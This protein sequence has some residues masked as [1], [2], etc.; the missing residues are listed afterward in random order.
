[1]PLRNG[2]SAMPAVSGSRPHLGTAHVERRTEG[3]ARQRA[4]F[5]ADAQR[6]RSHD[7]VAIGQQAQRR[8]AGS[9]GPRAAPRSRCVSG[10]TGTGRIRSTVRRA[11]RIGTGEGRCSTAQQISEEGAAP[12]CSLGSH[13]PPAKALVSSGCALDAVD[14]FHTRF[15]SLAAGQCRPQVRGCASNTTKG[16]D[17][18]LA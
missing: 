7:F 12:C 16:N 15:N 6:R 11:T 17:A 14:R 18:G 8:R 1:M 4:L 13:G 3:A 2:V 5:A 10:A 9:C